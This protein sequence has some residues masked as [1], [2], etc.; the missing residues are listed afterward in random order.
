M[1]GDMRIHLLVL[2]SAVACGGTTQETGDGGDGGGSDAPGDVQNDL[3]AKDVINDV[4]NDVV[5]PPFDA[6]PPPPIGG[7]PPAPPDGGVATTSV[8]TFAIKT[9]Y[10]GEAPYGGGAPSNTA[11]KSFGYDIDGLT[12]TKTS[13]NVC[14]LS[15]G[16]PLS[17]QIDGTNGID[18][19]FGAV[20]LPIIQTAASLPTPSAT[21]TTFIDQGNYTL[22]LQVTGLSD[23][24]QQSAVGLTSQLFTSGTYGNGTPAFDSSTD[25]PVLST[26]VNDGKTIASGSTVQFASSYVSNGIFVSGQSGSA[27]T[28]QL[29]AGGVSMPL[30]IHDAVITFSHPSHAV[31]SYGVISGVMAT[32]EFIDALQKVAGL[33]STSLC[34]SAF[35]GIADQIRQ[36]QD[37]LQNGTNAQNVPCSAISIG[38][39]FD[40]VLVHDPTQ[41]VTAPP[42]PPDPCGG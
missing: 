20:L 29:A 4:G 38:L 21:E 1:I 31:A 26:S 14:T 8:Y 42:G 6:G 39:G 37:I 30:T 22:Q 3:V 11:W 19:A 5:A 12:T 25:W 33:I 40:A 15:A 34:G 2:L 23:D 18:N 13:T 7:K 28:L 10:L 17:N 35:Q 27:I 16:A 9:L 32:Q 41:V 36:A 24:P